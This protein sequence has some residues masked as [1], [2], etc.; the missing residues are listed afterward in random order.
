MRINEITGGISGLAITPR[1]G[2][3]AK[4]AA[5]ASASDSVTLGSAVRYAEALR[6]PSPAEVLLT[7]AVRNGSYDPEPRELASALLGKAFGQ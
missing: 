5:G 6:E 7:A 3:T 1:E 4:A 2:P